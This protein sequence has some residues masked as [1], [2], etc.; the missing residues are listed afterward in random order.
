MEEELKI[1]AEWK[2]DCQGKKNYDADIIFLSTRYWPRGGGFWV[3]NAETGQRK[4]P[5]M[6]IKPSAKSSIVIAGRDGEGITVCEREFK[7]ETE[8]EVKRMVEDFAAAEYKK[9]TA[10]IANLYKSPNN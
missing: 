5:N 6:N 10:A 4:N 9:I 2:D 1:D 8:E 3:F 7:A